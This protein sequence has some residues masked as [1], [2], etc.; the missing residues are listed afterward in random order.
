MKRIID[1]KINYIMVQEIRKNLHAIEDQFIRTLD[2]Q[3]IH[4]SNIS[5]FF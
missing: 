1:H 5:H 4:S 2:F 3:A